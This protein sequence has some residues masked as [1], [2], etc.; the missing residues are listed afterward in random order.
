MPITCCC[1][2]LS[3]ALLSS[4]LPWGSSCVVTLAS[5]PSSVAALCAVLT[6]VCTL[7]HLQL[8][9][10]VLGVL[11]PSLSSSAQP[12]PRKVWFRP[13]FAFGEAGGRSGCSGTKTRGVIFIR[14]KVFR[15]ALLAGSVAGRAWCFMP[16]CPQLHTPTDYHLR[17]AG[18]AGWR[19]IT[20]ADLI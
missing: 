1:G 15:G 9:R 16:W 10:L 6:I 11:V 13:V 19:R 3:L 14:P 8:L 12:R 18:S 4:I 20:A 2:L 5:F 17:P 7:L